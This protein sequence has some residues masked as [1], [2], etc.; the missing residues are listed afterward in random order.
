M[1]QMADIKKLTWYIN[2]ALLGIVTVMAFLFAYFGVTY[3]VWHSIPTVA[4]YIVMYGLIRR[5]K[6][7]VYVLV[8]YIVI[9]AYMAAGTVCLG[10]DAGYQMYCAS[11]IPLAFYMSYLGDM[12]HTRKLNAMVTSLLLVLVFLI[13]TSFALIHGPI[14]EVDKRFIYRCM[15]GNSVAVFCFLI[16]YTSL[17]HKL[18]GGTE[19]RLAEMAHRDQLTGLFNRHYMTT[20]LERLAGRA[21]PGQWAAMIDIDDF[22]GINDMY[23]HLCGDYVLTELSRLMGEVCEGCVIARWGGEEFLIVTDGE[24]RDQSLIESLR[25]AVEET[26]FVFEGQRI[27]VTISAGVAPWAADQSLDRWIQIADGRLYQG[28]NGG[29][30]RVV[31]EA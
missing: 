27:P 10:F 9:T 8:I 13:S 22:K 6:L 23:G 28:K 26:A 25:R 2:T 30:N 19:K 20:Y 16:G 21:Q 29:K 31:Y 3:M 17:I 5:D 1:L 18:V 14:Y 11:L 7:D 12:L 4:A 24:A 15:V